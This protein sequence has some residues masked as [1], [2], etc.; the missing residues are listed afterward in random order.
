[1]RT[2]LIDSENVGM[3]W[4]HL[5]DSVGKQDK[6]YLFYTCN[7]PTIKMSQLQKLFQYRDKIEMVEC[8]CGT[9]NALDFQLCAYV[10]F[11]AKT[12]VK[13]EY[14][15]VSNDTGY[16]AM[17][18]FML[19]QGR[20]ISRLSCDAPKKV[21]TLSP[22]NE[23]QLTIENSKSTP[24]P[25]YPDINYSILSSVIKLDSEKDVAKVGKILHEQKELAEIHTALC[26]SYGQEKGRSYYVLIKPFLNQI[27]VETQTKE[28]SRTAVQ[29]KAIRKHIA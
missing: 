27:R 9:P 24:Y 6:I 3:A 15:I 29:S 7:S 25:K 2:Y 18:A 5:L 26:K 10:G 11:L 17:V 28:Q 16:D 23:I 13:T 20:N 8:Y 14:I 22:K 12:A 21:Q 4:T 19:K 1:M